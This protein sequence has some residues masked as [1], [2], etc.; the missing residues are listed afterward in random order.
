MT[1]DTTRPQAEDF[2][3]VLNQWVESSED[4]Q[5]YPATETYKATL[6]PDRQV[7]VAF[8][9]ADSTFH[10]G[11]MQSP[12]TLTLLAIA[13]GFKPW[14]ELMAKVPCVEGEAARVALAQQ[15]KPLDSLLSQV[16]RD[17]GDRVQISGLQESV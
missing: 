11:S 15:V 10:W 4:I 7:I 1:G 17:L 8:I 13:T 3:D 5:Y 14:L 9:A 2:A 16:Q 12:S 6:G